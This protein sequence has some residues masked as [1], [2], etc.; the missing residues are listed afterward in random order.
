MATASLSATAASSLG[1]ISIRQP[2]VNPFRS[3]LALLRLWGG[4]GKLDG[5][6][7]RT[8]GSKWR[9]EVKDMDFYSDTSFESIGASE[10][11]IKAM[12]ALGYSRPSHMQALA[13]GPLAR[14]ESC[15]LAD[16]AG[17]GKTLAYLLPTVE[18]LRAKEKVEGMA[19]G[20]R[21]SAIVLTPTADLA[22]QVHSVSRAL[23]RTVPFRS[24]CLREQRKNLEAGTDVVIGTPGRLLA[25]VDAESL[26]LDSVQTIVVDE[27]DVMLDDPD[28]ADALARVR[29]ECTS[30]Q[31]VFVT[32]TLTGDM[33][34][35][36]GEE[37][38]I[39]ANDDGNDGI[40]RLFGPGL[41]R[42]A[43]GL[44]EVLV[45]C[46]GGD[47]RTEE[48]AF[49]RKK[50]A[51]LRALKQNPCQRTIIFCHK[52]DTC[53]KL[54]NILKR[55]DRQERKLI[56]LAYHAAISPEMRARN[57][58]QFMQPPGGVPMVLI[59]TDRTSRGV[60]S[61]DV[62]HVVLF[63]FPRDP[64]RVP[65]SFTEANLSSL[66]LLSLYL[67]VINVCSEYVRRVGR[68]ARGA[69]GQGLVTALVLGK[70]V[71][72]A[73]QIMARNEKGLPVHEVPLEF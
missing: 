71:P 49:L 41:H 2:L 13:F 67:N 47:E 58:S 39:R 73:Q 63:D 22:A 42:T 8:A 31:F 61:L 5:R 55:E 3:R 52:I 25:L 19:P 45:D 24:L 11:V 60:D 68:T 37:F 53:R 57:L 46:S 28:F 38:G 35:R 27:V 29:A 32:A 7:S 20:R 12:T 40:T 54:E 14:G 65:S 23:A 9:Q 66:I 43:R 18:R 10:E 59:C 15:I 6:P 16:Q 44:K 62:E 26:L 4:R 70:L 30:A 56:P 64:R 17:S 1:S 48:S 36:I 51:L 34:A 33:H 50:D 21:P 72:M 69:G